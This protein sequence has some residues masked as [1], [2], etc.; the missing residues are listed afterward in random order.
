MS[1]ILSV[2]GGLGLFLLGMAVM[3]EGL[4]SITGGLLQKALSRFTQTPVKGAITG[5][6][7]TAIVQSSSA[8]T[9]IAVG[10]V[11][12]GLLSFPQ[13]LGVIFGANLG[14]TITG[15]LVALLG[16]KLSLGQI[17]LPLVFVGAL[18]RLFGNRLVAAW[19]SAIAG[20]ALVFIGIS[21]L[22]EGMNI[23]KDQVTPDS[24]PPNT[25]AGRSLLVLMG[26]A[27][28][29]V[30]QSSTAGVATAITAVHVG[31]VTLAQAAAMVIG[32][33]IGTTVTAALATIGGST[34]A[35]RTGLAHV[36][37][38]LITGI[39]A[40]LFLPLYI[41]AWESLA[42][43]TAASN[44]EIALVMFH[45]VFNGAGVVA[46][47]PFTF[48]FASLIQKIVPSRGSELASRLDKS[49]LSAPEVAMKNVQKTLVEITRSLLMIAKD[50]VV[51]RREL[52]DVRKDL[53]EIESSIVKTKDY[54]ERI[55]TKELDDSVQ[56]IGLGSLH[57]LDHL[58]RLKTRFEKKNMLDLA[59]HI[60]EL[61]ALQQSWLGTINEGFLMPESL[62]AS[63]EKFAD[64]WHKVDDLVKPYRKKVLEQTV[65]E[66]ITI[67]K[68][69]ELLDAF[70]WFRRVCHH[71]WRIVFHLSQDNPDVV[72]SEMEPDSDI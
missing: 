19:G 69:L 23:Y 43:K 41:M 11:G 64:V 8:T 52:Q 12:A 16:F 2:L 72:Q 29:L 31:N 27:I 60:T 51:G 38:N 63:E 14:T 54:M 15:W 49:L 45:T 62:P 5:T 30:T 18:M 59:R 6:I 37:Y 65:N 66:E 57:V 24:F 26:I 46:V 71:T 61:K 47:L 58:M 55:N 48:S 9:V 22:Q 20:F 32:M 7:S 42:P 39:A 33:D 67:Q 70:R 50:L 13:A 34:E 28:T 17:V 1:G 40:F 4:K 35:R 53:A 21:E 44:A 3:T 56:R 36:I 25:W 10:F 68:S